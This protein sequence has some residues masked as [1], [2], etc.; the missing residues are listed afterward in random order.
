MFSI[1]ISPGAIYFILISR[2]VKHNTRS[3]YR[4]HRWIAKTK[5]MSNSIVDVQCRLRSFNS[6]SCG[7]VECR[8]TI[9]P[10]RR[11]TTNTVMPI[12]RPARPIPVKPFDPVISNGRKEEIGKRVYCKKKKREKRIQRERNRDSR[13]RSR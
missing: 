10:Q 4:M 1:S 2:S 12:L 7:S 9:V 5:L 13:K 6:R 8:A 11:A 3:S